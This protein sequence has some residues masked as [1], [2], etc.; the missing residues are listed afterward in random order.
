MNIKT[1]P[2]RPFTFDQRHP[3][4]KAIIILSCTYFVLFL[5]FFASA[6]SSAKALRDSGFKNMGFY[7]LAMLYLNF[8]LSSL[9]TSK[10]VKAIHPKKTMVIASIFFSLWILSL[11]LTTAALKTPSIRENLSYNTICTIVLSVSF[12][13]GAGHSLLWMAQGKYLSDCA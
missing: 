5:A 7:S 13:S 8:G 9:W 6:N 4:L 3:N 11:A 10:V 1:D 12:V 2:A